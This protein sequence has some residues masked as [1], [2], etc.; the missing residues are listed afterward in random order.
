L[1]DIKSTYII[2]GARV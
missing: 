2:R 1:I